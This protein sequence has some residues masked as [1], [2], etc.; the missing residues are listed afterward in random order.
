MGLEKKKEEID[1]G[2]RKERKRQED[3]AGQNSVQFS[4]VQLKAEVMPSPY[5]PSLFLKKKK[6][7]KQIES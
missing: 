1:S 6:K 3:E 4:S 7:K 5:Y 2:G